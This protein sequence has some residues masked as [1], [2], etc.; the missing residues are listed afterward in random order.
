M[1][2]VAVNTVNLMETICPVRSHIC[3]EDA[4]E[5]KCAIVLGFF[6]FFLLFKVHSSLP[7]YDRGHVIHVACH[8]AKHRLS[9]CTQGTSCTDK[10]QED[11]RAQY[12]KGKDESCSNVFLLTSDECMVMFTL[13]LRVLFKVL[14]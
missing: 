7:E 14:N 6:F 1:S 12:L 9:T 5:D 11:Y 3:V 2:R 10:C 4:E 8:S 13:L